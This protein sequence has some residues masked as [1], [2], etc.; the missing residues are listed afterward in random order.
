MNY[1]NS[2][3]YP[4]SRQNKTTTTRRTKWQVLAV[5]APS[6]S[7]T[8]TYSGLLQNLDEVTQSSELGYFVPLNCG[9]FK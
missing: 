4:P 8:M 9:Q 2:L 5:D 1:H 3:I 7:L 6:V